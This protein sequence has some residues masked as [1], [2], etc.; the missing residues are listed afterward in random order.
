MHDIDS[1]GRQFIEECLYHKHTWFVTVSAL[2]LCFVNYCVMTCLY[3]INFDL[4]ALDNTIWMNS[5]CRIMIRLSEFQLVDRLAVLFCG[6]CT[7]TVFGIGIVIFTSKRQWAFYILKFQ[8]VLVHYRRCVKDNINVLLYLYE[9]KP[10]Y[11]KY[12]FLTVFMPPSILQRSCRFALL[13]HKRLDLLLDYRAFK[14]DRCG[15]EMFSMHVL[16]KSGIISDFINYGANVVCWGAIAGEV[17]IVLLFWF[18]FGIHEP[19]GLFILFM[20]IPSYMA[21]MLD[22]IVIG[23]MQFHFTMA[24]HMYEVN[25]IMKSYLKRQ[26]N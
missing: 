7:L 25:G 18:W 17:L 8:H 2:S 20:L 1:K 22:F 21:I 4:R 11:R 23:L 15:L 10:A 24:A 26:K 5:L 19:M 14:S 6:M 9:Q 3:L 13:H 16:A 12:S